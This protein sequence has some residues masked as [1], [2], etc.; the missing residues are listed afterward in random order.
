MSEYSKFI[1]KPLLKKEIKKL[2]KEYKQEKDFVI[3]AENIQYARNVAELFRI[4]DALNVRKIILTGISQKPPFGNDLLKVSRSKEK[5][6]PW[7]YTEKTFNAIDKLKAQGY[8]ITALEITDEAFE[9][10]S[11]LKD[12]KSNKIAIVIGNEVYGVTKELLSHCDNSVFLPM[13]GKGASMNVSVS[14]GILL[15]LFS[16]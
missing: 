13:Y 11:Y 9:I 15:Y 1:M 3:I 7:E 8:V 14:L 6:V 2:F 12:L 5:H 16:I 4:A 10:N